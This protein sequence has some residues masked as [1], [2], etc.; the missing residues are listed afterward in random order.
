MSAEISSVEHKFPFSEANTKYTNHDVIMIYLIYDMRRQINKGN[1]LPCLSFPSTTSSLS[2]DSISPLI[3]FK[4]R[5]VVENF[6][7]RRNLQMWYWNRF[8]LL[9]VAQYIDIIAG[10][11]FLKDYF[12]EV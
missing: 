10:L 6:V 7:V 2:E 12:F 8:L 9:N 5:L 3:S 1:Q 4:P 11:G